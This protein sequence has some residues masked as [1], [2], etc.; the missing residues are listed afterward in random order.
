MTASQRC[1]LCGRHPADRGRVGMTT[2][3]II[4]LLN[5]VRRWRLA[6]LDLAEVVADEGARGIMTALQIAEEAY[7]AVRADLTREDE[8]A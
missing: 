7:E 8:D 1:A 3:E 5:E 4:A 6:A 2:D